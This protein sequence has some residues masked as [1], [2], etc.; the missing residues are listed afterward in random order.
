MDILNKSTLTVVV[1]TAIASGVI[2]LT[3]NIVA[4]SKNQSESSRT[5]NEV[6]TKIEKLATDK[7]PEKNGKKVLPAVKN[8][9]TSLAPPPGPFINNQ[10]M[11]A[12]V[13]PAKPINNSVQPSQ[14]TKPSDITKAPQFNKKISEQPTMNPANQ[15]IWMQKGNA[16]QKGMDSSK[17]MSQRRGNATAGQNQKYSG[18]PNMGWNNYPP[19]QY[20]YVPVP[21]MPMNGMPPQMPMFNRS[22]T[23]PQNSWMPNPLNNMPTTQEKIA[24]V[25]KEKNK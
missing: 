5:N 1:A 10:A 13:A 16:V 2:L 14:L 6:A 22:I 18:M 9:T 11:S 23:P 4:D 20:M 7:Q 24:P 8:P 17:S 19:Q 15:P 25:Q 21:M 3:G 12:P